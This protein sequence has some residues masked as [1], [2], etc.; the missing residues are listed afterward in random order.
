[1]KYLFQ[2]LRVN[3]LLVSRDKIYYKI[4]FIDDSALVI[5]FINA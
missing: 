3:D 5:F 2:I 4:N 1:M